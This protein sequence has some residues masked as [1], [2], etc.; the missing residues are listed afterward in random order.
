MNRRLGIDDPPRVTTSDWRAALMAILV[1][2]FIVAVCS[3]YGPTPV[4][5]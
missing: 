5:R 2:A 1:I 4:A 3:L